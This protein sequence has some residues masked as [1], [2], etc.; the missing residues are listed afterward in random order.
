MLTVFQ[1]CIDMMVE[2]IQNLNLDFARHVARYI[3]MYV[4]EC[5]Y[6]VVFTCICM[7]ICIYVTTYLLSV[8]N[9]EYYNYRNNQDYHISFDSTMAMSIKIV[10]SIA[11]CM[12]MWD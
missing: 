3:A 7:Y 12:Y 8:R 4:F 1:C 2:S 11:T 6:A 9:S 5:I 10:T